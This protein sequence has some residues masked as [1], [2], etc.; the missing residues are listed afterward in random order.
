MKTILIVEAVASHREFLM[1]WRK[2]DYTVVLAV[3]ESGR[4]DV[5]LATQ[6]DV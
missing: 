5:L 2:D 3:D 6:A 1:Q 4:P